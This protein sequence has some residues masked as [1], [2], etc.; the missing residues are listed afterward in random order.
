M[1]SLTRT[2]YLHLSKFSAWDRAVHWRHV[3]QHPGTPRTQL[4]EMQHQIWAMPGVRLF[5]PTPC[6]TCWLKDTSPNNIYQWI[7]S[8]V[9][10][11]SNNVYKA[12]PFQL[13]FVTT[14]YNCIN[15]LMDPHLSSFCSNLNSKRRWLPGRPCQSTPSQWNFPRHPRQGGGGKASGK[16]WD[17]RLFTDKYQSWSQ[18]R[19]FISGNQPS[20]KDESQYWEFPIYGR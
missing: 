19:P 14:S 6:D 3:S 11:S 18:N 10:L 17:D 8:N 5:S 20:E 13:L 1:E 9:L 4:M 16:A 2:R 15:C 12:K 7:S